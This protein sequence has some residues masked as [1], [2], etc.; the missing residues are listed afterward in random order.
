[1]TSHPTPRGEGEMRLIQ[2]YA[3]ARA[4]LRGARVPEV[5]SRPVEPELISIADPEVPVALVG[6]SDW[7]VLLKLVAMKHNLSPNDILGL[8]R[9]VVVVVARRQIADLLRTHMRLSLPQIGRLLHRDHTSILN[10]LR[11]K[12]RGVRC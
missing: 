6:R 3:E 5:R 8:D 10:L 9:R 2:R 12:Q 7:R 4:R 1:M 11:G